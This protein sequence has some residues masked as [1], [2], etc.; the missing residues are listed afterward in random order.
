MARIATIEPQPHD[1]AMDFIATE[2]A[3][4]Q[5]S[6]DGLVQIDPIIAP[7]QLAQALARA[8]ARH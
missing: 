5:A 3:W 7:A 2:K 8:C 4:Y 1:I 6:P